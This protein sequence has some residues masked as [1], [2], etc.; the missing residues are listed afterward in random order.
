MSSS[1]A[2]EKRNGLLWRCHNS[3]TFDL[4]T[5]FIN[6]G[7]FFIERFSKILLKRSIMKN[8]QKSFKQCSNNLKKKSYNPKL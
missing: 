3:S 7:V 2:L 1:S 5:I 6:F 4:D 8:A